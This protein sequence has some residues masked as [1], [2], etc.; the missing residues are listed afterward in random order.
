MQKIR[1][2]RKGQTLFHTTVGNNDEVKVVSGFL[3][4]VS[5]QYVTT[6]RSA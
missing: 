5:E 4:E 1:K 3:W 6:D 2:I